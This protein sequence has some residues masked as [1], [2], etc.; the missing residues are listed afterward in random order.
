MGFGTALGLS[1][2]VQKLANTVY[3]QPVS[4]SM[5]EQ[6]FSEY[7]YV[8]SSKRNR[9][10]ERT[11][12]TREAYVCESELVVLRVCLRFLTFIYLIFYS[13]ILLSQK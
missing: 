7:D 11:H 13:S 8:M 6:V 9:L 10:S 3:R 1:V 12:Y 4:Q 2:S 5:V